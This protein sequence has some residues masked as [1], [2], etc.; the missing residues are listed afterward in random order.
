M[1]RRKTYSNAGVCIAS[2]E[3]FFDLATRPHQ[4]THKLGANFFWK[5]WIGG[6]P[7]AASNYEVVPIG[8]AQGLH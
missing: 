3:R 6:S 4:I 8:R 2:T 7:Q 1:N 5:I